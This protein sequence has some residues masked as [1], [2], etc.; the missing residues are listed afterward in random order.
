MRSINIL[1]V[2][3]FWSLLR[4]SN[5]LQAYQECDADDKLSIKELWRQFS[6]KMAIVVTN[7]IPVFHDSHLFL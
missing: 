6:I 3:T 5:L 4:A 1:S 7:A 2:A